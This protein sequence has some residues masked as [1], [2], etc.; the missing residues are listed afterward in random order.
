MANDS[1]A[2][3]GEVIVGEDN[4]KKQIKE[5]EKKQI[6][7]VL[8]GVLNSESEACISEFK[9]RNGIFTDSKEPASFA[10]LVERLPKEEDLRLFKTFESEIILDKDVVSVNGGRVIRDNTSWQS[11]LRYGM[12]HRT[13]KLFLECSPGE[14]KV[15]EEYQVSIEFSFMIQW[16]GMENGKEEEREAEFEMYNL[17]R[18]ENEHRDEA[19][20]EDPFEDEKFCVDNIEK[21]LTAWWH[22]EDSTSGMLPGNVAISWYMSDEAKGKESWECLVEDGDI[23]RACAWACEHGKDTIDCCIDVPGYEFAEEEG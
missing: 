23:E 4:D 12:N 6:Q 18:V 15:Q 7:S 11:A 2:D 17:V 9:V 1:I 20:W 22:K 8:V 14:K 19:W 21:K 5:K 16:Y 13:G 10:N 3:K